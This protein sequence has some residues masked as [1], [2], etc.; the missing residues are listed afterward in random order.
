LRVFAFSVALGLLLA[1]VFYLFMKFFSDKRSEFMTF[2][3][4]AYGAYVLAEHFHLSGILTL[5]VAVIGTK[6]F[7]DL[8]IEHTIDDLEESKFSKAYKR[9]KLHK[10]EAIAQDRMEYIYNMAS[11]LGYIAT[12][13][14]FFVLAEVVDI[15][16]L[17]EYKSEI[18]IMFGVTT[19]IRAVS[20][21]K[22]ALLG[23]KSKHIEPVGKDGWFL[24]TFSG[25]KGA[26][27]I[28]LVHMLPSS[29]PYKD[30][31]EAVTIGVVVLSI[32]VYGGV[33]WVYFMFIKKEDVVL[34]GK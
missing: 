16:K 11:E 14:I 32:F 30:L 2:I 6:V 21:A 24:L 20:M 7:V 15:D 18:F 9:M 29:L 1:V 12:A 26:L 27:S 31:F 22:F 25:M 28:I 34:T 13:I 4:E 33:L 23:A 17:M 8:D 19:L 5:I 10:V 3:F